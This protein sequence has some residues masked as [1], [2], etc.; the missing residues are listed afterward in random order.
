MRKLK[1]K[2]AT[3]IVR[4]RGWHLEERHIVCDGE[5]MSGALVDFGLYFFHNTHVRLSQGTAPY[6]YLPKM[7]TH[8]ETRLWND[9][10]RVA[11]DYA[12]IPQGMDHSML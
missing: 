12:Q 8:L 6:F 9:V 5:A 7:E 2:V 10:F 11:Q 1:D 3:L 4:T